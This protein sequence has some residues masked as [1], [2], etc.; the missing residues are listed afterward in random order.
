[1]SLQ[2]LTTT[3]LSSTAP[4]TSTV[5]ADADA[6]LA[7]SAGNAAMQAQVS[8]ASGRLNIRSGPGTSYGIIGKAQTQD[9]LNVLADATGQWLRFRC[10]ARNRDRLG[11]GQLC[12]TYGEYAGARHCRA[13]RFRH[14]E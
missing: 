6:A 7:H 2:R 5:A 10:P 14:G 12:A 9:S 1:M 13:A 11:V 4:V 3:A 8:L